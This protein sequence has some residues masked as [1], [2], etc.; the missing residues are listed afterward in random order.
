ELEETYGANQTAW[1][2]GEYHQVQFK[3]PLSAA[4]RLLGYVFNKKDPVPV[5]G[6]AVTPMAA[7]HDGT[8]MVNHGASW[9]FV[10]DMAEPQ[11]AYHIVAPGQSGHLKSPWYSDQTEDWVN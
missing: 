5:D 6:S 4:N 3:H 11:K 8:G 1:Q 2:W 9:R 10:I 7:K